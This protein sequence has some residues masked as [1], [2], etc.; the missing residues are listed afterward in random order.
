MYRNRIKH[1]SDGINIAIKGSNKMPVG[2]TIK[3]SNTNIHKFAHENINIIRLIFTNS[4]IHK[5]MHLPHR[6]YPCD[7]MASICE[8][9]DFY[10]ILS[11]LIRR[12]TMGGYLPFV[13]DV[14]RNVSSLHQDSHLCGKANYNL[15]ALDHLARPL[16]LII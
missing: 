3:G 14:V 5:L 16:L 8:L 11:F 7:L 12:A 2:I 10:M 1:S 4:I 6:S 9:V 13:L 15:R